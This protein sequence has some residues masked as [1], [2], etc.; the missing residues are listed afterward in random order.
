[1][2]PTIYLLNEE[3]LAVPCGHQR[4][5]L[6]VSDMKYGL[7]VQLAPRLAFPEVVD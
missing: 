6:E 7:E 3:P 1:M 2:F 4:C 5:G